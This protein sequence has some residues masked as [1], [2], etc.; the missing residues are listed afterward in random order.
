M[1]V[2]A[3]GDQFAGGERGARFDGIFFNLAAQHLLDDQQPGINRAAFDL[4]P[5]PLTDL[6]RFLPALAQLVQILSLCQYRQHLFLCEEQATMRKMYMK[7]AL[8]QASGDCK[9]A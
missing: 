5:I 7:S 4:R 3:I 9:P 2:H 8:K 1:H 6:C